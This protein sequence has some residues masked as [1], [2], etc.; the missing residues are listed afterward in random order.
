MFWIYAAPAARM[1]A[2]QKL[3]WVG[4]ATHDTIGIGEDGPTHQPIALSALYRSMPNINFLRPAD[5]EEVMGAWI[6]A[7]KDTDR[8]SLLLLSRQ[9]VPLLERSDRAKVSQGA[10][11]VHGS[12]AETPDITLVSSGT[13]VARSIEVADILS[14]KQGYKVRVVSMPSMAHFDKQSA[15]YR[16]KTIP[17]ATSL[18]VGIEPWATAQWPR[19]AHAGCHMHSFGHSAPEPVLYEH[20]GFGPANLAAKIG[21][22]AASRKGGNGIS[23][24]GVGEYAEL[25][26]GH[27][28]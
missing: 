19:Y 25:L 13:E 2:L 3:Q 24:P 27:A 18:V 14:A 5:P 1:A 16:Q 17:T 20:F 28:H 15:E 9:N 12:E 26:L 22:W 4:V 10:Y 11:V 23:I 6:M 8:P 21:A 7:L